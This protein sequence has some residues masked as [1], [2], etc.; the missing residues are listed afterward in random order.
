MRTIRSTYRKPKVPWNSTQIK[1]DRELMTTYGLRRKRE[2]WKAQ[3]VLRNYRGRARRLIAANDERKE[4]L[5][6]DKMIKIGLLEKTSGLDDILTLNIT[7]LLDRRLQSVILK[8]KLAN[9]IKTARQYIG[10]GHV[11]IDDRRI[12]F[13]SYIVE[14]EEEAKIN[15]HPSSKHLFNKDKIK[16]QVK[17]VGK[18]KEEKPA[19]EIKKREEVTDG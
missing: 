15:L 16:K 5:L 14:A 18:S 17:S 6:I 9:D 7:N 13:P 8:K 19:E 4:K 1:E 3:G 10:H 12:K 2:L 11:V